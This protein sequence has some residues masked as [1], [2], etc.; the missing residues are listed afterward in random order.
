RSLRRSPSRIPGYIGDTD[1]AGVPAAILAALA[2]EIRAL[3]PHARHLLRAAALIGS[4]VELDL[5]VEL[6]ELTESQARSAADEVVRVGIVHE[7]AT[8]GQLVFR[9][10]IVRLAVYEGAGYGWR[11]QA[12]RRAAAALTRRGAA[13]SVR[14]HHWEHCG[15]V[16]DEQ[17]IG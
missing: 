15:A 7:S 17:A 3:S 4:S 13:L 5:A 14:A 11:T 10:P 9:H 16:G 12:H 8:P 1:P 6:S 2:Q